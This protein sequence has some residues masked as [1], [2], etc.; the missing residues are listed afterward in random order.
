MSDSS[1]TTRVVGK[2]SRACLG[3][4]IVP[5]DRRATASRFTS[6]SRECTHAS[7]D[8]AYGRLATGAAIGVHSGPA[9]APAPP[10]SAIAFMTGCWTGPSPNGATIE[11][12]YSEPSENLLIGM[13]PLRADRARGR[14]RVHDRRADRLVVR[15]DATAEGREVR[16]LPAQGSLRRSRDVGEPEA[17]F[18]A[19]HHLSA[20]A[21][22]ARSSRAS[23]ERRRAGSVT[24]NGPCT[25]A[26]VRR[27]RRA[28]TVM[29]REAGVSNAGLSP[30][31]AHHVFL[32]LRHADPR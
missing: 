26:H 22:T 19:A 28:P 14:L 4:V 18:P 21:P 29:W 12:H 8:S 13:T 1:K 11:E 27:D 9:A 7:F 6:T 17:R 10:L 16:L 25:A 24:W 2:L 32:V 20:R 3:R 23:R 30:H 5:T 31:V 15:H